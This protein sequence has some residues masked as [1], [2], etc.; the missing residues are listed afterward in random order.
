MGIDA[1]IEVEGEEE[2]YTPEQDRMDTRSFAHIIMDL[3]EGDDTVTQTLAAKYGFSLEPLSLV[4]SEPDNEHGPWQDALGAWESAYGLFDAFAK[5]G[6][7]LIGK[8]IAY[9]PLDA[10]MIPI[11]MRSLSDAVNIL[12]YAHEKGKRIRLCVS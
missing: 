4:C 8:E 3:T 5:E 9:Y 11:Y 12:K 10:E 2:V 6:V 7:E 1:C